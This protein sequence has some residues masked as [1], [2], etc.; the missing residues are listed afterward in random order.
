MEDPDDELQVQLCSE[1][2]GKLICG[3]G[4][5][6][7]GSGGRTAGSRKDRSQQLSRVW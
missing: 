1:H 6:I 5:Q 2:V 7:P 4:R 3:V